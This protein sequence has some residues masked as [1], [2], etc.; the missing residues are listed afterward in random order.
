MSTKYSGERNIYYCKWSYLGSVFVNVRVQFR[1]I[2][3]GS[4]AEDTESESE[5]KRE[6]VCVCVCVCQR[7]KEKLWKCQKKGE[8]KKKHPC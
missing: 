7:A 3:N 8:N 4:M 5:R 2:F 6:R 1:H